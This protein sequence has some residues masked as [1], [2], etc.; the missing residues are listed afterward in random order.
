[1]CAIHL[2]TIGMWA[3]IN[4]H[5]Y[6]ARTGKNRVISS[7]DLY[8]CLLPQ[9][10]VLRTCLWGVLIATLPASAA[11]CPS[12]C[13]SSARRDL[14]YTCTYSWWGAINLRWL[15]F[16]LRENVDSCFRH[17]HTAPRAYSLTMFKPDP[18][19]AN[20][21]NSTDACVHG[22][23]TAILLTVLA[24]KKQLHARTPCQHQ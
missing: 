12:H 2:T 3:M 1:M 9:G 16:L 20:N 13:T 14:A 8:C 5:I 15:R 4:T 17:S 6:E 23:L 7:G 19:L 11:R 24:K 10:E 21:S 22:K 18:V